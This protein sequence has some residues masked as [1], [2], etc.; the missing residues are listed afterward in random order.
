NTVTC[1][2]GETKDISIPF[3]GRLPSGS[4]TITL[5]ETTN[6]KRPTFTYY[7]I[8]AGPDWF[9]DIAELS[10]SIPFP[11]EPEPVIDVTP[12]EFTLG[13]TLNI[14]RIGRSNEYRASVKWDTNEQVSGTA[15]IG[16]SPDAID[17][18]NQDYQ[19][20][21]EWTNTAKIILGS[22]EIAY[23]TTSLVDEA[24]NALEHSFEFAAPRSDDIFILGQDSYKETN[25]GNT[26][27][28]EL[29]NLKFQAD[30]E[31][32]INKLTY[33][34][35]NNLLF[36]DYEQDLVLCFI[37]GVSG[38]WCDYVNNPT[39]KRH[40]SATEKIGGDVV[41]DLS[42]NPI[43]IFAENLTQGTPN[44]VYISLYLLGLQKIDQ[45]P[46]DLEVTL[47]SIEY[48]DRTQILSGQTY[49]SLPLPPIKF[50]KY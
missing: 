32:E 22:G 28:L 26:N 34:F 41:I 48:F 6:L 17:N 2:I 7:A 42:N 39:W 30:K 10:I 47:A 1:A 14:V 23:Y 8:C 35:K 50:V 13:P 16:R 46:Q 49:P 37:N 27:V 33:N 29:M 40:F 5:Q 38:T 9:T 24:G 21:M 36:N 18:Y 44:G 4:V 45:P 3:T 31:I 43:K 25:L 11:P 12:P 15:T 20:N 19:L